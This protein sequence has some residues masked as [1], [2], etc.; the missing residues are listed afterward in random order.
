MTA[1]S[2]NSRELLAVAVASG[3]AVKDSAVEIGLSV[4]RAY[5]ISASD[6]FKRRVAEI[7]R[8]ILDTAVGLLNEAATKAVNA[9][10][11][12]LDSGEDKDRIVA[13]K[14]ILSSL[15]PISELAEF[16]AR[17]DRLESSRAGRVA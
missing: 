17:I 14:A 16:R 6:E 1:T 7:R 11:S 10:V 3:K 8:E 9:L 2:D 13:A 4:S 15:G 5:H 12:I